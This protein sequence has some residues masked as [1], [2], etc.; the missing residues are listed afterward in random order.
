MERKEGEE[1][2]PFDKPI[3]LRDILD[4]VKTDSLPDTWKKWDDVRPQSCFKIVLAFESEEETHI[5]AYPESPLLI[6]WYGCK[7]TGMEPDEEHTLRVWLDYENYLN[8]H[9]EWMRGKE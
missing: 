3:N 6:P 4:L 9:K 2:K 5:T 7:V 1:M 8:H